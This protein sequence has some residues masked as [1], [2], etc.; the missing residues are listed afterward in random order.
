MFNNLIFWRHVCQLV[1]YFRSI[2]NLTHNLREIFFI[3]GYMDMIMMT[4]FSM[5]TDYDSLMPLLGNAW[6][7]R[8]S[9]CSIIFIFVMYEEFLSKNKRC[10]VGGFLH[11]VMS[12]YLNCISC[13]IL[14]K[15]KILYSFVCFSWCGMIVLY[16]IMY[17]VW[18]S[19]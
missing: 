14:F 15:V 5:K 19:T 4:I 3:Q 13:P 2:V 9:I 1:A 8:I 7:V 12:L 10:R 6:Y 11:I 18:I 16:C 17:W